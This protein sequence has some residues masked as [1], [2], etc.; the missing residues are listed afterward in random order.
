MVLGV[1]VGNGSVVGEGN[2]VE[3]GVGIAVGSLVGDGV[4]LWVGVGV[5]LGVSV[6]VVWLVK[7]FCGVGISR[8]AKSAK[9]L[10]ES[11]LTSTLATLVL[12]SGEE[13]AWSSNSV[14]EP[15][16]IVSIFTSSRSIR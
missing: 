6:G 15:M 11:N 5:G 10:S 12:F 3:V 8:M 4:G 7:E 9:L 13:V 16:P 1:A 14:A 2:I